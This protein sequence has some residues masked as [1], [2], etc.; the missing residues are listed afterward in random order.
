MK[1]RTI[2]ALGFFDGVH[3]GHQT[4]L[5]ACRQMAD[6]TGCTAG[7]VTFTSHPDALVYG[8]A[9]VLI[10]T[11]EDRKM[12][13]EQY[14]IAEVLQLP[15]DEALMRKPWQ[16]FLEDLLQQGAAGFI[17]GEDFR[18]GCGGEGNAQ[19]LE[20]F[21]RQHDLLWSIIPE[22]TLEG[23]R[24]SS[25]YIR[26]LLEQGKMAQAVR[27]LGHPHILTGTVIHG[28]GLGHTIGIPTANL[29]LPEGIVCPAY[30]VYA[31]KARLDGEAYRAVTNIGM[32]PTVGGSHVT[33]EAYLL[34]FSGDL[35]GK[36]L[37]LEFYDFLRPEQKFD[38]LDALRAQIRQDAK[39]VPNG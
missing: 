17:C 11:P 6:F 29:A 30:G 24:I 33:V 10:N 14:H 22:Q 12:L 34:D 8:K 25:T 15:F 13:L 21:C 23:V 2:Y 31:C 28:R 26:T 5:T 39:R 18:F 7:A 20:A 1:K 9:P 16:V 35:Y 27:F 32:R 38:S 37:T 4:L 36:E 3:R 19:R